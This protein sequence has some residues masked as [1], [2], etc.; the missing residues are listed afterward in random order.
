MDNT[1]T[2]FTSAFPTSYL[3]LFRLATSIWLVVKVKFRRRKMFWQ[4][5]RVRFEQKEPPEYPLTSYK[6]AA[7]VKEFGS[8]IDDDLLS[9]AAHKFR[10]R[11]FTGLPDY[12]FPQTMLEELR[13]AGFRWIVGTDFIRRFSYHAA[14]GQDIQWH[15]HRVYEKQGRVRQALVYYGDIPDFAL[16]RVE[17]AQTIGISNFTIHSILPMPIKFLQIDPVLVGWPAMP[18]IEVLKKGKRNSKLRFTIE[19]ITGVVIA[20]WDANRELEV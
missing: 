16:D 12:E 9:N 15:D 5:K 11:K 10:V 18:S 7:A 8:T 3:L 6:T 2:R 13:M 14:L 1:I 19:D 20:V 4:K 17:K